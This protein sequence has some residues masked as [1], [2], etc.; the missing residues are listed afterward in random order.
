M[1]QKYLQY[2]NIEP[3]EFE[4]RIL[5]M[6]MFNDIEWTKTGNEENCI[7]NSERVKMHAKRFPRGHWTFLGP[8]DEKKWYGIR[9]DTFEGKWVPSPL[10]WWNDSKIQVTLLSRVPVL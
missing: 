8:G 10:R 5:F 2:R 7:S 6:S 1:I 9:N 4:H 3:E